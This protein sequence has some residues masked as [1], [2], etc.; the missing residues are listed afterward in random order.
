MNLTKSIFATILL[1]RFC[2][3]THFP[4]EI[5]FDKGKLEF[6]PN[7]LPLK[8]GFGGEILVA[9]GENVRF[10]ETVGMEFYENKL[11]Y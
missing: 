5:P 4:I 9:N 2:T 10:Q 6:Y 7:A 1:L 11:M 3:T 8:M